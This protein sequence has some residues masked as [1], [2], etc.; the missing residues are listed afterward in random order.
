MHEPVPSFAVRYAE[1]TAVAESVA[2]HS[3][4]VCCLGAGDFGIL[5][6][7]ASAL[8]GLAK[9]CWLLDLLKLC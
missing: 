3:S 8:S 7:P 9:V 4:A 2:C 6:C 5:L 1:H